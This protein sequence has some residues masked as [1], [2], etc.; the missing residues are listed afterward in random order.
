M[1]EGWANEKALETQKSL[2]NL[3]VSWPGFRVLAM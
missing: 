1:L 3:D 2:R